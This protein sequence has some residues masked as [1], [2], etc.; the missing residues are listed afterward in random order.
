MENLRFEV[1]KYVGNEFSNNL[2]IIFTDLVNSKKT[3]SLGKTGFQKKCLDKSLLRDDY[4]I[5]IC[6]ETGSPVLKVVKQSNDFIRLVNTNSNVYQFSLG[7]E[8]YWW[9]MRV[10]LLEEMAIC[11]HA[12]SVLFLDS[13]F[14]PIF[15]EANFQ[16]DLIFR[17]TKTYLT[18]ISLQSLNFDS[19]T[20]FCPT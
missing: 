6:F 3:Q 12:Q 19:N 10:F 14:F 16:N 7:I 1:K 17:K 18:T 9:S 13:I 15:M 4:F 8:Q 5:D 20:I 11:W 2:E